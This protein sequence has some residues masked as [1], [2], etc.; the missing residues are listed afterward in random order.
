MQ[1]MRYRLAD[2]IDK[3]QALRQ[4][5]Y[6]MQ[7]PWQQFLENIMLIHR[8]VP[9]P[10]GVQIKL[11]AWAGGAHQAAKLDRFIMAMFWEKAWRSSSLNAST[12]PAA[13]HVAANNVDRK[14]RMQG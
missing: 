7:M 14:Q 3:H 2:L 13:Y 11:P 5:A 8:G 9:L 4:T 1:V 6:E 10:A 12:M